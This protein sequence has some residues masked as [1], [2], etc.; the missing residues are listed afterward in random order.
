MAVGRKYGRVAIGGTFDP[1]HKGHMALIDAAFELGD[2]VVIGISSD[3]LAAEL[4]KAPDKDFSARACELVSYLESK[5]SDRAYSVYKL[6]DPFGPLAWDPTIEAVV[7]SP[8][9]EQRG[10]MANEARRARG[11]GEVDVVRM[12]FVLAEDGLP[13]SSTR[14]RRGEI[15]REG[16]PLDS[17][18]EGRP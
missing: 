13:I 11:L 4:G 18:G 9:T 3:R 1:F 10:R 14:I 16:H 7:V 5:Y 17:G 12:D 2:E 6:Q 8:E 15:D